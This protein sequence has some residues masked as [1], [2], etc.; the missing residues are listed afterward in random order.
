MI[1]Q[2]TKL[3][4]DMSRKNVYEIINKVAESRLAFFKNK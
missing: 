3:G 2:F 1:L 4:V